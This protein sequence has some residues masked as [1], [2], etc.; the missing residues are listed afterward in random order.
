MIYIHAID[1]VRVTRVMTENLRV[2]SDLIGDGES[3]RCAMVTTKWRVTDV[4]VAEERETELMTSRDYWRSHILHG[5][6]MMRFE[7]NRES[8]LHIIKTVSG[9]G[10]MH[11]QHAQDR[12]MGELPFYDSVAGNIVGKEAEHLRD[13]LVEELTALR[14][15]HR[16]TLHAQ[17]AQSVTHMHTTSLDTELKIRRINYELDALRKTIESRQNTTDSAKSDNS[18]ITD[19][20]SSSEK[21]LK[22]RRRF[23]RALRW[24]GRM[25]GVGAAI[26]IAVVTA[27]TLT[28]VGIAIVKGIEM[29]FQAIK[30]RE[31]A[32]LIARIRDVREAR[33]ACPGR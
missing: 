8:A 30:N 23:Y 13:V 7:D 19:Q 28:S 2:F 15:E 20:Q 16:H 11:S 27:G 6:V 26:A 32:L 21:Q 1:E 14:T 5:A 4:K 18:D 3:R 24:I 29:A 12:A 25:L 22:W 17:F 10:S 9:R 31:N 33:R